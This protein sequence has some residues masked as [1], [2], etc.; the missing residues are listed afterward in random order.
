MNRRI[1]GP[2]TVNMLEV[3]EFTEPAKTG[4]TSPHLCRLSDDEFYYV[5]GRRLLGQ[6][7]ANE[8]IC[9]HLGRRL[10]LRIPDCELAMLPQFP[11]DA[12][13]YDLPTHLGF[14]PVFA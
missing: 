1:I 3:K 11:R 6:G 13:K 7:L 5:M 2:A 12:E 10:G 4:V 9:A 8:W 14:G